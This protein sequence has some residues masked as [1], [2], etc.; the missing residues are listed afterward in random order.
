MSDH[1]DI[2]IQKLPM[3]REGYIALQK[4]LSH[5]AQVERPRIAERIRDAIADDPNL[6]ENARAP[7]VQV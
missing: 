6:P 2:R 3:T 1:F 4:D 5:R 7:G